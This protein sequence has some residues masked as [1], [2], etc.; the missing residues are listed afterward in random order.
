MDM[1]MAYAGEEE[2]KNLTSNGGHR[3]QT[4]EEGLAQTSFHVSLWRMR[5]PAW[6]LIS[7]AQSPELCSSVFDTFMRPSQ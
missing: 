2:K 6:L 5:L 4:D 3:R 1:H 7:G